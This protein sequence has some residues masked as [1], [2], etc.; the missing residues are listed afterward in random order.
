MLRWS[1]LYFTLW[2]LLL[3]LLLGTTKMSLA[4]SSQHPPW[5]YWG[6][7][8]LVVNSHT[9]ALCF[10][11]HL[12]LSWVEFLEIKPLNYWIFD[13]S[14]EISLGTS[15]TQGL[16]CQ[17][18]K[19]VPSLFFLGWMWQSTWLRSVC[20]SLARCYSFARWYKTLHIGY[21]CTSFPPSFDFSQDGTS[22]VID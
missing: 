7:P 2:P 17:Q 12:V 16:N 13:M 6:D 15:F 18:N 5:R 10:W 3:I 9:S 20:E 14:L 11:K 22:N 1:F 4:P 8:F 19:G 21:I